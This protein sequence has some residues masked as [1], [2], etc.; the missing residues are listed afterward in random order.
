MRPFL[1]LL[2]GATERSEPRA[3]LNPNGYDSADRRMKFD[4]ITQLNHYNY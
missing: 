1:A 4:N 2:F 3:E